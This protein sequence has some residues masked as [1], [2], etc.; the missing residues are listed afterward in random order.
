MKGRLEVSD[1]SGEV[2]ATIQPG[3][4][5]GEMG[6]FTGEPRSANVI[7]REETSGLIIEKTICRN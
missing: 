3:A 4:S 5:V 7:G 1:Q 2:L 6:A